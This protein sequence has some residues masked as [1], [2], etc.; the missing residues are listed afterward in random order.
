VYRLGIDIGG[1]F[2]D[3]V[4]QDEKARSLAFH[5]Q[6]TTPTDVLQGL[7][8]GIQILLKRHG[9]GLGQ[10]REIRHGTTLG[11]NVII[12]RKGPKAALL[13]TRGFRDILLI[14]RG[15]RYH[16]FDLH[17]QK[18]TPLIPRHL[19]F[20]VGERM[21]F[22]GDVLIPLDTEEV[23]KIARRLRHLGIQTVAISLL[24]AYV[25]PAH[26]RRVREVLAQ[27]FPDL[28]VSLS[29]D[30][31]LQA[32]EY[33]RTSTTV[34][35]AYIRPVIAA[36]L[37]ELSAWARQN[38]FGG[39]LYVMQCNGGLGTVDVLEQYPVRMIESGPAAGVIA[40]TCYGR[41]TGV[42]NVL[43]LDMGGTTAKACLIEDGR[44]RMVE[45][46]EI[47]R[48]S[49][50]RGSG[51]P[52]DTPAVDLVEIGAGGGSMARARLG[53][54]QVG[55]ESAGADPGP[56]C[57]GR[58]GIYP[59]VTD[60]ALVLGYLN[61]SYFLGGKMPLDSDAAA[62][63]IAEQVGNPLGLDLARA[64]WGIYEIVNANMGQALRMVSVARGK[65]P[66]LLTLVAS[67]GAGPAHA[68]RLARDLGIQRVVLPAA[69]GVASALG[70]LAAD[71]RFDLARTFLCRISGDEIIE[72]I[73]SLT[74]ELRER[75]L[76]LVGE[77]TREAAPR[78]HYEASMR[79]LGQGFEVAVPL[80]TS[81]LDA[82]RTRGAA[83]LITAFQETYQATYGDAVDEPVEA[84][85]WK[86]S[87]VWPSPGFAPAR[88]EE[89]PGR[90]SLLKGHRLAFFPET[91]GYAPCPIYDRSDV[92]RG[93]TIVGPAIVED[94]ES[95]AVILAG[96]EAR[97]DESGNLIVAVQQEG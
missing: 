80:E 25:N 2:T 81:D 66:R 38:G 56:I 40:A 97:M 57:Y 73:L 52:L 35:N 71:M 75:A 50:R 64:A 91:H 42:S 37:T 5:K 93:S 14:Q 65:D 83:V 28:L 45:Q 63:G 15:I 92:T 44:P 60:A 61:P 58:G 10:I 1:T 23:R 82:M 62:R 19:T 36:Y 89:K 46:L 90:A 33:E 4:L 9:I 18:P 29:S 47:A 70:L 79:Y 59:T 88:R 84:V 67:G 13:V 54:I 87:L 20:E 39:D 78:I 85:Q 30:L 17:L 77:S 94:P 74:S 41:M 7:I 55:P 86:V 16:M 27:E 68:C 95:T 12:E 6:L 8:D 31:S 69:A 26:E 72:L 34:M 24:H 53:A 48:L 49:R 32:R 22:T 43:A 11:G 3:F 51:L 96:D 76:A 21:T